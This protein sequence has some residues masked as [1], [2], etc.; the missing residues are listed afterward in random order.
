MSKD[1]KT[2]N[3][4]QM[5]L[6]GVSYYFKNSHFFRFQEILNIQNVPK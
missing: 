6:W 1:Y 4:L 5:L 3:F 2:D